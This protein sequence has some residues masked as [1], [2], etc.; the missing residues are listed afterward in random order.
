MAIV[1][2]G[3]VMAKLTCVFYGLA[4]SHNLTYLTGLIILLI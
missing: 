2:T 3:T 1:N 4:M